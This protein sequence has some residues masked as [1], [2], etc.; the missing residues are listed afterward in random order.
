MDCLGYGGAE[1]P[2]PQVGEDFI[3][4]FSCLFDDEETWSSVF[5]SNPHQEQR[6]ESTGLWSYKAYGKVVAIDGHDSKAQVDCGGCLIPIPIE[7]SSNQYL[8]H[9]VAFNIV[10]LDVW[11]Q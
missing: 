7:V 2:Y 5:D 3:P 6:L 11:R 4:E 9:F 1:T 8:G 10:R